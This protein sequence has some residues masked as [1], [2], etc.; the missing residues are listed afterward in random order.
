M[1][2]GYA[3]DSKI[4]TVEAYGGCKEV[5]VWR[6]LSKVLSVMIKMLAEFPGLPCQAKFCCPLH[7]TK[8]MPIRTTDVSTVFL[9]RSEVLS[10][11]CR[12]KR[13]PRAVYVLPYFRRVVSTARRGV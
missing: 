11:K 8:G 9:S 10:K 12:T 1:S 13:A 7:K 5:H 6:A 4:L 3:E 2:L